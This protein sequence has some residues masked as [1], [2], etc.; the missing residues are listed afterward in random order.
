VI[1]ALCTSKPAKIVLDSLM[2]GIRFVVN[3]FGHCAALALQQ[4]NPR[5]TTER[6]RQMWKPH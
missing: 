2:A 5:N 1:D 4:A 6:C 3:G